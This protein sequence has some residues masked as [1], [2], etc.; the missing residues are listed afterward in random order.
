[1]NNEPVDKETRQERR[2][3]RLKKK[4]ERIPQHGRSLVKIYKDVIL[5]RLRRHRVDKY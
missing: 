4:Q 1:M 3:K 2:E 5:K